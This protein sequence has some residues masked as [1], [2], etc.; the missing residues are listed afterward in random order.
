MKLGTCLLLSALAWSL[1]FKLASAEEAKDGWDMVEVDLT[2]GERLN[3][4]AA[5]QVF[6][7]DEVT[8][9]FGESIFRRIS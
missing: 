2:E 3:L 1:L 6:M 4:L 5:P 9:I 7:K 8:E